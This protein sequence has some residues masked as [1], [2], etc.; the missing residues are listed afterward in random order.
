MNQ[1]PYEL[2]FQDYLVVLAVCAII[3]YIT[4]LVLYP[5]D[6]GVC[7]DFSMEHLSTSIFCDSYCIS[8]DGELKLKTSHVYEIMQN[9]QKET[10]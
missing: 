2:S 1:S 4:Y 5:I 7:E 8:P 9:N 6:K 10:K 3:G